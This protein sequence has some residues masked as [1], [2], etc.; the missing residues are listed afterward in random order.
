MLLFLRWNVVSAA[1]FFTYFL[2]LF[3]RRNAVNAAFSR[4][5]AIN[6]AMFRVKH[7]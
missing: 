3:L 1:I 2:P 6:A 7:S 5:N 4:L